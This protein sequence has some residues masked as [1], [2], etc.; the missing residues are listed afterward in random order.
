[1]WNL[2]E[3]LLP[4]IFRHV[5]YNDLLTLRLTCT[6]FKHLIHY[7]KLIDER[8]LCIDY[9]SVRYLNRILD[10][11]PNWINIFGIIHHPVWESN[12]RALIKNPENALK[13]QYILITPS[14]YPIN[15]F[16]FRYFLINNNI[17]NFEKFIVFGKYKLRFGTDFHDC[18]KSSTYPSLKFNF[19]SYNE[20]TEHVYNCSF[21][22]TNFDELL[23][24]LCLTHNIPYQEYDFIFKND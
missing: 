15:F 5:N 1:M 20:I 4:L 17:L 22:H 19:L 24:Y 11:N 6:E 12:L 7:D 13:I 8:V 10:F 18:Y 9:A 21:T 16:L 3:E 14:Y 23:D 2:P